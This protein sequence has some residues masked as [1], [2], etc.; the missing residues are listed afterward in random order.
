MFTV[1][2]VNLKEDSLLVTESRLSKLKT[3]LKNLGKSD[4]ILTWE[5]PKDDICPSSIAK[6]FTD[7]GYSVK[8]CTPQFAS[9][10]IYSVKVPTPDVHSIEESE[11]HDFVEW[12]GMASL[13]ADLETNDS[14]NFVNSYLTPE[15]N[16]DIGQV[17]QLQWRGLYTVTQI[18]KLLL[19]LM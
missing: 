12:L 11:I 6:Y 19:K 17:K 16:I 9:N 4:V 13:N 3:K 2:T 10:T 14:N 8:L 1:I 15:P 5:P 18:Q 7:I